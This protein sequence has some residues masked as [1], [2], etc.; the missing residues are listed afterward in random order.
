MVQGLIGLFLAPF[1]ALFDFPVVPAQVQT[2]VN[3]I[4]GYMRQGMGIIYFFVPKDVVLAALNVFLACWLIEHAYH[5]IKWV[6]AKI[7]FVGIS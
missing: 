2:A 5:L 3:A 6:L 1:Q 4:F 7:P